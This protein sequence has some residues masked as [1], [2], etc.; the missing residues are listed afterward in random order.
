MNDVIYVDWLLVIT[1]NWKI[2]LSTLTN[3]VTANSEDVYS[4]EQKIDPFIKTQE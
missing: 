4:K 2:I 1:L 3:K